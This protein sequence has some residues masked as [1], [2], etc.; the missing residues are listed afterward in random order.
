MGLLAGGLDSGF[1]LATMLNNAG[2]AWDN[3]KKYIE[4]GG[5][6]GLRSPQGG[7]RRRYRRRPLQ[8]HQRPI[9]EHP[10][11]AD[12]DGQRGVHARG[13][14]LLAEDSGVSAHCHEIVAMRIGPSKQ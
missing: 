1:V 14:A 8:G 5:R 4:K 2:G 12:D 3:A 11:Q 10:H 13:V 9:A 6:K 7:C